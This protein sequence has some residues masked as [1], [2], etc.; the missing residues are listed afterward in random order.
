MATLSVV[1]A[2]EATLPRWVRRSVIAIGLAV[3][4]AGIPASLITD[5]SLDAVGAVLNVLVLADLA[6]ASVC[7]GLAWR[8][9]SRQA[10]DLARSWSV[11]MA[12]LALTQVFDFN[13]TMFGGGPQIAVLAAS[14]L[15]TVWLSITTTL[16]LSQMRVELDQARA[17]KSALSELANRD[18]LTGLLNRRGFVD[19]LQQTFIDGNEAPL[20]LLLMDVDLFKG[21]NDHFGHEAGDAVLCRIADCFRRLERELCIAGRMGGEEFVLAVSGLS[22]FALHRF[23]ES[24]RETIGQCDHGEVSKHRAVTVSVGVAE[25]ST[26]TSFQK[27]YGAA[28]RALYEAKHG[29]RNRVIFHAG[30]LDLQLREELDRDQFSFRWPKTRG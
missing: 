11:P 29:G 14:A 24:V 10:R 27:L 30:T 19:C 13:D 3:G 21:V 15:Q 8:S 28:D 16:H 25:G 20:A 4:L 22:S 2:L 12:M 17:A 26:R 1:T 18:P 5:K 6:A 23:A 9:G 7:I